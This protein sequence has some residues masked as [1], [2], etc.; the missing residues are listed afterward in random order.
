MKKLNKHWF[1]TGRQGLLVF[2]LYYFAVLLPFQF[3]W[4]P[5]TLGIML[6]GLGWLTGPEWGKRPRQL[7][8]HA[9]A[10]LSL[11]YFLWLCVGML[12]TPEP[13]AG[14]REVGRKFPFLA[15]PLML[16][17][18]RFRQTKLRDNLIQA[19][20]LA[21]VL[22]GVYALLAAI[23][24][25]SQTGLSEEFFFA[26]LIPFKRVPP[27]YFGMFASFGYGYLLYKLTRGR[28]LFGRAWLSMLGML[29]LTTTVVL[30]SV[31]MQYITFVAVHFLVV[32]VLG[33][34]L[35]RSGRLVLGVALPL[36]L[37]AGVLLAPGSRS[38]ITDAVNEMISFREMVNQKQ[39]NHRKYLWAA[40]WEVVKAQPLLGTGTGAEDTA[41]QRE[42]QPIDARFW[43]GKTHYFLR[44]KNYNY[45][46]AFLQHWAGHGVVGLLLLIAMLGRGFWRGRQQPVAL[47]FALVC[48]L[49]FFSES[50]LQRQA[51]LLFFSFFYAVFFVLREDEAPATS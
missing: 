45:H 10:L 29:V 50:M 49:S 20:V 34:G 18:F 39:T 42:V 28:Y 37:A 32:V 43:D 3:I 16:A 21:V 31:R 35:K 8:G 26:Q 6:C 11:G 23:W 51:G 4:L 47:I 9:A 44:D 40:G 24:R 1:F 38:R 27:H 22:G 14:W 2:S 25:Y 30:L 5:L 46:N 48:S 33:A 12:Y 36:L 19:F 17:T 41:L 7:F 13:Q 15:W